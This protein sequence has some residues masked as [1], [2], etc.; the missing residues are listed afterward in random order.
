MLKTRIKW[1]NDLSEPY[2]SQA[3]ENNGS[4]SRNQM[5]SSLKDALLSGFIWAE[6]PQ[7]HSYW[8]SLFITLCYE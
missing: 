5:T 4:K 7:G 2:R 3:I 6:S 1:L 8:E